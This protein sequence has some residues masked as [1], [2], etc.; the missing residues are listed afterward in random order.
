[1]I[2]CTTTSNIFGLVDQSKSIISSNSLIAHEKRKQRQALHN[3]GSFCAQICLLRLIVLLFALF[4]SFPGFCS[5]FSFIRIAVLRLFPL[6]ALSIKRLC[7]V[8]VDFRVFHVSIALCRAANEHNI[9]YNPSPRS[10][11]SAGRW[12]CEV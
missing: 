7:V 3:C 1:M 10:P 8:S 12:K 6:F 5:R 9:C 4:C 2:S 11:G